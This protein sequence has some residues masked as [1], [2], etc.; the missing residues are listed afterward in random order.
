[1]FMK[2]MCESTQKAL[3]E[4]D[5]DAALELISNQRDFF[6]QHLAAWAPM[7]T[8]DMKRLAKTEFYQGLA[9]LTE[10]FLQVDRGFLESVIS[11]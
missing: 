9:Y 10:G 4:G 6:Q 3:D 8:T 11:H 5:E 7:M 1:L 2:T